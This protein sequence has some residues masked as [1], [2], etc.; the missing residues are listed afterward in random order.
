M[1]D[2]RASGRRKRIEHSLYASRMRHATLLKPHI[3][4]S[5]SP[6]ERATAELIPK[7]ITDRFR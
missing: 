7:I 1:R 6:C 4:A 3:G 2:F 5:G